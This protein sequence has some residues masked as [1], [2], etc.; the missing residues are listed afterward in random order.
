MANPLKGLVSKRKKRYT[1]DGFNLDLSCI[2]F[3]LIIDI[4]F[5]GS[6]ADLQHFSD[7]FDSNP[8]MTHRVPTV[9]FIISFPSFNMA[10]GKGGLDINGNLIAMGFPAEKLEGVFRNHISDVIRFLELKHK[11]HYKIYNLCSERSYDPEKFKN[12]VSTYAFDD[13][14]PPKIELIGPF[15]TDVHEWIS[16]NPKNVAAVHCKAGKGRTGVMIC[17]YMLHS[18]QFTNA[19]DAL[20][21]YG[22]SRTHDKKGVTIPSQRRYVE[23]YAQIIQHGLEYRPVSLLLKEILLDPLPHL[24]GIQGNLQFVISDSKQKIYTSSLYETK[25]G[26]TSL[27]LPLGQVVPLTGDIKVEFFMK[28]AI[29]RKVS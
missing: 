11:D 23:Y 4:M 15:C 6:I 21:F 24:N 14:N 17:C 7:F 25:K 2:L 28:N 20:S 29:R 8:V 22:Q 3:K 9:I 18:R 16:Q 1:K 13:H 19:N 5:H 26:L 12:R 27:C 10:W